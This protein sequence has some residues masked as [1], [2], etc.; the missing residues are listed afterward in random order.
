MD[1]EL[2]STIYQ[3]GIKDENC[4]VMLPNELKIPSLK[5]GKNY[6]YLGTLEVED[7]TPRK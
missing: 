5:E 2:K 3:R 4:D 6:K 7:I 1:F